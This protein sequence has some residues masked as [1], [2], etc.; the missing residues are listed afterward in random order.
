MLAAVD[1][2]KKVAW[3]EPVFLLIAC[4]ALYWAGNNEVSLWDRD[5]P[6]YAETA[7]NMRLSGDYIVPYFNGEFRFQKPVLTYWLIAASTSLF[8]D[9][10]FALRASAGL[11]VAAGCLVIYR[12][13]NH[14]FGRPAGLLAAVMTATAPTVLFLGKLCIPD[15]P[16]FFFACVCFYQLYL[17]WNI[18]TPGSAGVATTRR[19]RDRGL[20]WFWLAL[21]AS[22]LTKGPIVL[23]MLVSTMVVLWLLTRTRLRDFPMRWGTGILLLAFTAVPWFLCIQ[24]ASGSGFFSESVGKQLASRS[25]VSFDGRWLPPGYYAVSLLLGFLPWLAFT[26]LAAVRLREQ[27]RKPGPVS[28]LLAWIIGPMI[29]LELFRSKQ[30]HYYAPAYPALALLAAGY[31]APILRGEQSWSVDLHSRVCFHMWRALGLV[32]A[33]AFVII[34]AFGPGSSSVFALLAA[35]VFTMGSFFSTASLRNG[36]IFRAFA[37][38]GALLASGWWIVGGLVL[39]AMERE[40]IVRPVA[41]SLAKHA[42]NGDLIV[43]RELYEPSMVFYA[44]IRLPNYKSPEDLLASL[45]SADQDRLMPV[46]DAEL[47]RLQPHLGSRVQIEETW[48]GWVKM[49]ADV[50]HLIRIKPAEEILAAREADLSAR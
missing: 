14:M 22:I 8:G 1:S 31:L 27:W 23:G 32:L 40:R 19:E 35:I 49:H 47:K 30:L 29:L 34:A 3:L 16:Q 36:E 26:G 5:E 33:V 2:T 38:Q 24:Y 7:R 6:R 28:F 42:K 39:P 15:G 20:G 9:S 50:V 48:Q 21:S 11:M 41:E 13:G 18:E 44:G 17:H 12:L 37:I 43:T 10:T 46:T 45:G 25:V 4:L